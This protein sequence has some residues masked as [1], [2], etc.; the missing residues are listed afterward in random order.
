MDK[1]SDYLVIIPAHNEE[2]TIEELVNRAKKYADVCVVNDC[3]KDATSQILGRI[4][5]I[6]VINHEVNT[7]IP[8]AVL[9]GMRFAL[10][11]KYA[12][13]CRQ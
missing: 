12:A 4:E 11:N 8:G 9:D 13:S 5:N 2:K 3:S 10:E 1:K 6:K 7:H